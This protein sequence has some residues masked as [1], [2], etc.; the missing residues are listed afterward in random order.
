ML[1]LVGWQAVD[2][3]AVGPEPRCEGAQSERLDF[4]DV[5]ARVRF[6]EFDA[7]EDL[8]IEIQV[9]FVLQSLIDCHRYGLVQFKKPRVHHRQ[10]S[11]QLHFLFFKEFL[12]LNLYLILIQL[13]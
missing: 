5:A 2:V 6:D 9:D 7:F 3:L 8:D 1:H 10:L 13:H 11:L 12:P 4:G